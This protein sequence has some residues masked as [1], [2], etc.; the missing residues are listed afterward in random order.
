MLIERFIHPQVREYSLDSSTWGTPFVH[1]FQSHVVFSEEL[2]R[3]RFIA[4]L[5]IGEYPID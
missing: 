4:L 5:L 2:F 3:C 1:A